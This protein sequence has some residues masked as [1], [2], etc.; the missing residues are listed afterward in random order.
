MQFR[1]KVQIFVCSFRDLQSFPKDVQ[2]RWNLPFCDG[3]LRM[4]QLMSLM[5]MALAAAGLWWLYGRDRSL[6]D[7]GLRQG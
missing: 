3:G 4:A 7:P 5:L 2:K 6:P 1:A